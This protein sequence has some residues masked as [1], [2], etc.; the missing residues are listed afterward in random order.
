MRKYSTGSVVVSDATLATAEATAR[1]L[2]AQFIGEMDYELALST[3]A[4]M[5]FNGTVSM[6]ETEANWRVS[7][8]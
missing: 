6:W 2:I 1:R 3:R 8:E 5:G 4:I 7:S